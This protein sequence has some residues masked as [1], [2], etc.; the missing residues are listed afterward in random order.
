MKNLSEFD[1]VVVTFQRIA[2]L[3][4][5]FPVIEEL[6]MNPLSFAQTACVPWTCD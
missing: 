2:Q 6:D 3:V 4:T 1:G 5:Y